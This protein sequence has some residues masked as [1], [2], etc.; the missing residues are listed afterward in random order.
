M[1]GYSYKILRRGSP[2]QKEQSE[3]EMEGIDGD[4]TEA[5]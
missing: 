5:A 1:V 2:L 3:L 4:N